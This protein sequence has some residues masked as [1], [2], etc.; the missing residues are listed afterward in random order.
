M[1]K[2]EFKKTYTRVKVYEQDG[3]DL[4]NIQSINKFERF[5][6]K[7]DFITADGGFEWKNENYQEQEAIRLVLGEIITALKIQKTGGTFIIKLLEVYD[8]PA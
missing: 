2:K 4:T 1:A 6:K 3:G 7:A 8:N 5:S